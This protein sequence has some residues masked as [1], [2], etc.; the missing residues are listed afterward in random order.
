MIFDSHAHPHF[1]EFAADRDEMLGQCLK[2]NI[3]V[4]AV[5]CNFHDSQ[6]AVDLASRYSHVW[7]SV[8][9]HPSSVFDETFDSAAFKKLLEPKVVAIGET[10]LD[11]FH[12]EESN[13][14]VPELRDRQMQVFKDHLQL[15][16]LRDL[17]LIVHLRN[18][19]PGGLQTAYTDALGLLKRHR[20]HNGV[21]HS[22][23]GTVKEALDFCELGMCIGFTANITY[24]K[25]EHLV[26]VV[27]AVPLDK[28]LVETDSPF[29]P[30]QIMRGQRNEPNFVIEV[31]KKIAEVKSL[32]Y[33]DV[34]KATANNTQ[35]LFNII[36]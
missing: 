11:Y 18:G 30:P 9:L 4:I 17:P 32:D 29:L 1:G 10:G 34:A 25:N 36:I 20:W 33:D 26:D 22:F 8:G 27:Q 16:R 23:G 28:I 2:N 19:R 5:G 31:I 24:P 12:T 13:V 35:K 21:I 14:S 6:A 7:A 15:A 3:G